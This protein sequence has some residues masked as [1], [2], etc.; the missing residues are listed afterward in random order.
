MQ[1]SYKTRFIIQKL[2]VGQKIK[3][4]DNMELLTEAV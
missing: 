3:I 1:T 2:N 4:T